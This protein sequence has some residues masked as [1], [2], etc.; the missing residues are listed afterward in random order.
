MPFDEYADYHPNVSKNTLPETPR[1]NPYT[2]L[3]IRLFG[4]K[5]PDRT[6]AAEKA[7]KAARNSQATNF[8]VEHIGEHGGYDRERARAEKPGEEASE[9]GANIIGPQ[10]Y[11]STNSEVPSVATSRP[12]PKC[13][14]IAPIAG[15]AY[16]H[17][18]VAAL[19]FPSA[20]TSGFRL[21]SMN[22]FSI[23][24]EVAVTRRRFL[25]FL[26]GFFGLCRALAILLGAC[27]LWMYV[28]LVDL[29]V[30]ALQALCR[31]I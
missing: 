1:L 20:Q 30:L 28:V 12:T 7:M 10:A 21:Y 31:G 15:E 13:C 22:A 8:I 26:A 27:L 17:R 16:S 19:G 24:D 3:K 6:I 23:R 5:N 18:M 4:E 2:P 14:S 29:C 25:D 9:R 11:P